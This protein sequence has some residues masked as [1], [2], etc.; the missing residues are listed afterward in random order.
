LRLINYVS[1]E[2]CAG[3]K[4]KASNSSCEGGCTSTNRNFQSS[5]DSSAH[6]AEGF[7]VGL[8]IEED[9]STSRANNHVVAGGLRARTE[10]EIFKLITS[11]EFALHV[12]FDALALER[13]NGCTNSIPS[14]APSQS[15]IVELVI[16]KSFRDSPSV[17]FGCF[18][19]NSVS[20][21]VV[22]CLANIDTCCRCTIT[23]IVAIGQNTL[24]EAV[25][26]GIDSNSTSCCIFSKATFSL[27]SRVRRRLESYFEDD[28]ISLLD[29]GD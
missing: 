13:V 26:G 3:G 6:S 29:R 25:V 23:F 19:Q 4:S 2:E 1:S 5:I 16:F 22:F 17:V 11:L 8:L 28:L 10:V 27:D 15:Q 14:I 12:T 21:P 7:V 24:P 18:D 20:I 9:S